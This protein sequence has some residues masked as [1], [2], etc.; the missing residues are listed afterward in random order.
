MRAAAL[1]ASI[2][3][4]LSFGLTVS[5]IPARRKLRCPEPPCRQGSQ[6][7]L[8]G[9]KPLADGL[10]VTASAFPLTGTA[11]LDELECHITTLNP[12]ETPHPP[13]KHPDEELVIVKEGTV[14]SLV[15]A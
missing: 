13:H 2:D 6:C 8:V 11:T 10:D 15:N 9:R 3:M 12:G 5:P 1:L 14:E 4:A 7:R